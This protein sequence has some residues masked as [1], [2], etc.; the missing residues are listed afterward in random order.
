MKKKRAK[1]ICEGS[2]PKNFIDAVAYTQAVKDIDT[3]V[4]SRS[5]KK[6]LRGETG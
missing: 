3:L 4:Y 5:L 2:Y 6:I 1:N